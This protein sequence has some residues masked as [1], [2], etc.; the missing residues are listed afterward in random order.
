MM[1]V[2]RKEKCRLHHATRGLLLDKTKELAALSFAPLGLVALPPLSTR[3]LRRGL[4]S[5]AA[6]R[7]A[8]GLLSVHF[9]F[10][11]QAQGALQAKSI[12]SFAR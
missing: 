4:H 2:S 3:G 8:T 10:A 6:S 7:L 11:L 5:V 1:R 9:Q 12:G